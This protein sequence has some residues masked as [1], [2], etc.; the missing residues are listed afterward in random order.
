MTMS[1]LE[2]RTPYF[3]SSI[4]LR[5]R[6]SRVI[7]KRGAKIILLHI[8]NGSMEPFSTRC[9]SVL[10]C[11]IRLPQ[12]CGAMHLIKIKMDR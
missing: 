1:C 7:P 9:P 4:K 10:R 2:L 3:A 11:L 5:D 12:D 8:K 6:F